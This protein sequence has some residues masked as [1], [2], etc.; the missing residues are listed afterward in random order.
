MPLPVWGNLQKSQID[1]ETIEEAIARLIQAHEDDPNAHIEAGESLHSHKA[2]EIIDHVVHSIIAD[3]IKDFEVG[4]EKLTLDRI[5]IRP[6]FES[7]DAWTQGG[8]GNVSLYLG[9]IE[10][11]AEMVADSKK[12]IW[13][14]SDILDINWE[15]KDAAVEIIAYMYPRT[16]CIYVFGVGDPD[17]D[18]FGFKLEDE[19]LYAY[20]LKDASEYTSQITG[21]DLSESH[22]FRCV[23]THATKIEF[24]ID[25]VLKYTASTNIPDPP[26]LLGLFWFSAKTKVNEYRRL[27]VIG[28]MY[29]QDR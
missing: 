11:M 29:F 1:P 10:V 8:T 26:E 5:Y 14:P 18:F 23:L 12:Y 27:Y 22:T 6:N 20:W 28:A 13:S 25:E 2:A 3:K 24:Y 21:I 16:N 9:G 17:N 7:L 15:T 4:R 19:L